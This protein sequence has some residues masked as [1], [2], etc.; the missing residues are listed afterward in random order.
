MAIF[1]SGLS[2]PADAP[3]LVTPE[4][5]E[6]FLLRALACVE[7]YSK[8]LVIACN[9]LENELRTR[10]D[11]SADTAKQALRNQAQMLGEIQEVCD[12]E[13]AQFEA[14]LQSVESLVGDL[15][16]VDQLY[17]DVMKLSDVVS[18]LEDHLR[19]KC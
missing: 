2:E 8:A 10:L 1:R 18:T 13:F 9:S 16:R 7:D 5:G 17:D 11:V 4:K 6:Q 14:L 3:A 12:S 19:S 15:S